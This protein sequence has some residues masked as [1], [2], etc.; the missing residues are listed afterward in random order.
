MVPIVA[1]FGFIVMS[2]RVIE[3]S[4]ASLGAA[5]LEFLLSRVAQTVE[6]NLQLGLPL[7]ELQQ[8][9]TILESAVASTPDVLAADVISQSGVT[10]FSTDRGAVGEPVPRAWAVAMEDARGGWRAREQETVTFGEPLTNDFGQFEGWIAI[11]VDA[12]ALA[13][14][15]SRS[16]AMI[17][18]AAPIVGGAVFAAIVLGII[19]SLRAGRGVTRVAASV[20]AR[21]LI[22]RP[23]SALGTAANTAVAGLGHTEDRVERVQREL[24]RLDAEL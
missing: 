24:R 2:A 10:L 1:L 12:T 4:D 17:V 13:P 11:I 9:D 19:V 3:R 14:P 18:A 16:P 6:L 22:E 20:R 8:V 15:L 7:A 5:G 21:Q 23:A